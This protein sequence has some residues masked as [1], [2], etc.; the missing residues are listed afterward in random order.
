M[1]TLVSSFI[2]SFLQ[3]FSLLPASQLV[4]VWPEKKSNRSDRSEEH[5]SKQ[6]VCRWQLRRMTY[7]N[8]L[9]LRKASYSAF[10][11][12]KFF[13]RRE[14]WVRQGAGMA[15]QAATWLN[16]FIEVE[17]RC[18]YDS[19]LLERRRRRQGGKSQT[20]MW[21][22][23]GP[24]FVLQFEE[25]QIL[26]LFWCLAC[27][28][29]PSA[30]EAGGAVAHGTAALL[31]HFLRLSGWDDSLSG[32]AWYTLRFQYVLELPDNLPVS[33]RFCLCRWGVRPR[34]GW[35]A[36]LTALLVPS[37]VK[38]WELF[39]RVEG[40]RGSGAQISVGKEQKRGGA[41]R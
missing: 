34:R 1:Y 33:P 6:D 10:V 4:G 13:I 35:T 5:G 23:D 16:D 38:L 37:A 28:K 29:V 41:G 26:G 21:V 15:Q 2:F 40:R 20:G 30:G 32:H 12:Q 14:K 18:V 7:V 17:E 11:N 25:D 3:V 9:L 27:A 36:C 31:P 19:E 39:H 22:S 24:V 8:L